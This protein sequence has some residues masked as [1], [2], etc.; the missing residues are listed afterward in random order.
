MDGAS[1]IDRLFCRRVLDCSAMGIGM[2]LGGFAGVV[3]SM[4][5][6]AV[7]HVRVMRGLFMVALSVVF[8]SLAVVSRSMLMM[9]GSFSMVFGSFVVLHPVP[10]FHG[11]VRDDCQR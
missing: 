1:E 6:V 3:G 5:T 10:L 8:S 4:K 11:E 2:M 9:F 7:S